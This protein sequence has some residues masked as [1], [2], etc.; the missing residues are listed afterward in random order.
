VRFVLTNGGHNG[1]VLSE[2]GHKGRH[3]R[4]FDKVEGTRFVG[5]DAW[6]ETADAEDGSCWLDWSGWLKDRSKQG[7]VEADWTALDRAPGT[8]VFD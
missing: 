5:P 3:Y 4:A 1:G 8:Y 2:P 6:L 7:A